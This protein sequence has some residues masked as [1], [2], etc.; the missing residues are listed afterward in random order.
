MDAE[1]AIRDRI[2]ANYQAWQV[3]SSTQGKGGNGV[4]LPRTTL[5]HASF[6]KTK[7]ANANLSG[8]NLEGADFGSANF[9]DA[10]LSAATL[11]GADLTDVIRWC[12][13]KPIGHASIE[14][15]RHTPAGVVAFAREQDAVD[16][17]TLAAVQDEDLAAGYSTA[18]RVS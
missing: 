16:A 4:Q 9:T 2:D 3:I 6:R 15:V 17:T 7:L 5:L 12:E 14:G 1:S 8:A 13:L 18:F 10:R 11:D